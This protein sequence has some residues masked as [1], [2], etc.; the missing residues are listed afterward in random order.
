MFLGGFGGEEGGYV[1]GQVEHDFAEK[2]VLEGGGGEAGGVGGRGGWGGGGGGGGGGRLRG[3]AFEGFDEVGEGGVEV[4]VLGV[5][6]AGLHVEAC[7]EEG[8]GVD[9][10]GG[11]AGGGEGGAGF[12]LVAEGVV[13]AGFEQLDFDQDDFVVEAFE[14]LEERVDEREGVVVGVFGH[15]KGDEAGFEGLAEE[16]AAFGYG[17]RDAGFGGADLNVGGVGDGGEEVQ[18]LADEFG[19]LGFR[20][21]GE[22]G[23]GGFDEVG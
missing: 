2:H 3:V 15:V 13:D 7:L 16:G 23:G 14:L 22:G 9:G 6:H 17:P 18:E 10:G 1:C 4:L 12:G 5:Q 8:R 19:G 11:G 20:E 21:R